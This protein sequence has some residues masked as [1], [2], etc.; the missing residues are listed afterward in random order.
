VVHLGM[1]PIADQLL[2]GIMLAVLATVVLSGICYML[3]W[4]KRA[5]GQ[6]GVVVHE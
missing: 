3:E 2:N 5:R 4:G 6:R 1:M